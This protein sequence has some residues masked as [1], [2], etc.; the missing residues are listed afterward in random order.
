MDEDIGPDDFF[1]KNPPFLFL[2]FSSYPKK[3]KKSTFW[4]KRMAG[5]VRALLL[6]L[7]NWRFGRRA[8]FVH[9]D[10]K[11]G[12]HAGLKREILKKIDKSSE[13]KKGLP[14]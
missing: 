9:K 6:L 5:P 7:V 11:R 10:E 14:S 12:T 4:K 8:C 3:K 13:K 2:R 1:L